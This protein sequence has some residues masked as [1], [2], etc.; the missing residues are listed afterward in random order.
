MFFNNMHM[1]HGAGQTRFRGNGGQTYVYRNGGTQ[2]VYTSN[3]GN[4]FNFGGDDSDDGD[5]LLNAM[6]GNA[7]GRRVNNSG[8]NNNTGGRKIKIE[9]PNTAS[10]IMSCCGQLCSL[11]FV[12]VFF[13]V[14][15]LFPSHHY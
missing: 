9:R 2:Y 14:P 15:Y 12:F 4:P 8:Q 6:F 10:M 5:E 13:V 3:S 1:H 11:I 7:F